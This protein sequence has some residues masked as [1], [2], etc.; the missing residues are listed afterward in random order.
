[1][2]ALPQKNADLRLARLLAQTPLVEIAAERMA[3]AVLL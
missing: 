2:R 3:Q 1:M